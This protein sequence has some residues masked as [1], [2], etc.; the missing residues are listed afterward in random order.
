MPQKPT[1]TTAPTTSAQLRGMGLPPLCPNQGRPQG[2]Q[3]DPPTPPHPTPPPS[4]GPSRVPGTRSDLKG[5]GKGT[6]SEGALPVRQCREG[7][8]LGWSLNGAVGGGQMGPAG[9]SGSC[10]RSSCAL[11]GTSA[12]NSGS[13]P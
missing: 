7:Q 12:K 10:V 4:H 6:G 8:G 9:A 11:H 13:K 5:Q 1:G 2:C 3:Q